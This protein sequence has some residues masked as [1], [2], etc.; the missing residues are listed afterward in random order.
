MLIIFP[1]FDL[2]YICY[3][4]CLLPGNCITDEGNNCYP[5]TAYYDYYPVSFIGYIHFLL[6]KPHAFHNIAQHLW[7]LFYSNLQGVVLTF[8][9][10]VGSFFRELFVNSWIFWIFRLKMLWIS[11]FI[12]SLFQLFLS[13]WKGLISSK[14]NP[15]VTM[16]CSQEGVEWKW[17]HVGSTSIP[18]MPGTWYGYGTVYCTGRCWVEV[19]SC[20]VHLYPRHAWHMVRIGYSIQ[21]GVEC[22]WD[23][24]GSTFIPGMP[25]TW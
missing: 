2:I 10:T 15:R 12:L 21:E 9:Y 18:G 3:P 19:G 7:E 13:Y 5:I 25:G 22:R 17:E 4:N 16:C 24:V 23:H 14:K 1:I 6:H 8:W 20:G 11:P